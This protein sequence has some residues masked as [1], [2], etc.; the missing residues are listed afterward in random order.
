MS[1][2]TDPMDALV[3]F[4]A[5]YTTLKL[6]AAALERDLFVH[7]DEPAPEVLRY[8]YA[9]VVGGVVE[10]IALFV[11]VDLYEGLPCLQTGY[12]VDHAFRRQG[13][14]K[15]VL[16][17]SIAELAH[18]FSRTP[19]EE[20]WVE[21]LVGTDNEASQAVARAVLGSEGTACTDEQSGQPAIAYFRKV[22]SKSQ[23]RR[24]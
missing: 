10:A 20:F 2:M 12:A 9:R 4:K 3:G 18:G 24:Y 13:R 15:A 5:A 23:E 14:A 11:V 1:A 7:L 22:K 16:S 19:V 6:Q 8:T 21:A 17:A